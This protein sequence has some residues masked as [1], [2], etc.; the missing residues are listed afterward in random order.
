MSSSQ[1]RGWRILANTHL[2]LQAQITLTKFI[3]DIPMMVKPPRLDQQ[4]L[5]LSDQASTFLSPEA[6]SQWCINH[7]NNN[8]PNKQ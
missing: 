6:E 7:S 4:E 5:K 8:K 1:A 3:L 2:L